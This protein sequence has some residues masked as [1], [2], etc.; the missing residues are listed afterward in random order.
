M[1]IKISQ[2]RFSGDSAGVI[3]DG[4]PVDVTPHYQYVV[5]YLKKDKQLQRPYEMWHLMRGKD[6]ELKLGKFNDIIESARKKGIKN[7]INVEKDGDVYKILDG[8]HRAAVAL[9]LGEEDIECQ[10][11]P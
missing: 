9:A 5:G 11:E 3:L 1:R 8:H 10:M 6:L 4:F 7:P 2:L